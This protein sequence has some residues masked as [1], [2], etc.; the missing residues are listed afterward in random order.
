[1]EENSTKTTAAKA[2]Q[3][4]EFH[5]ASELSGHVKNL[6][7]AFKTSRVPWEI[8]WEELWYNYLGQYNATLNWRSKTEGTGGRSKLFI[9]LTTLKCNTAHAKIIDILFAGHGNVPFD[10]IVDENGLSM[11]IDQAKNEVHIVKERLAEHFRSIEME[12]TMDTGILELAIL[13]TGV[14]KAPI[15]ET[16]KRTIAV[17]RMIAGMPAANL[18]KDISPFEL[19]TFVENVAAMDHVPL[20]EYYTD[21]NAL[22]NRAAIGEIHFQRLLPARFRQLASNPSYNKEAIMEAARRATLTDQ[23]ST[24]YVQLADNYTGE[25]GDKDK[26]VS[27]LEYWGLVPVKYLKDVG[28]ELPDGI[29]DED[30]EIEALVVLAADGIVCKACVN[31]LGFRPF[32]VCP[33]KKRPHVIYGMGVAEM[34]R[35]SQKMGNSAIR[36]MI[37]NKA[38]SGNGMISINIDRIDQ[39][40]S[41]GLNVFPGKTFFTKGQYAPKDAIDSISFPDVTAGLLDLVTLCERFS[42]EET[43]IP[44]YSSGEQDNFMNKTAHGMAMLMTQ[45]NI[46]LKSTLKNIDNF[47]IEPIVEAF[48]AWFTELS[49]DPMKRLPI[50]VKAIGADSLIAKELKIESLLKLLQVT[51]APSDAILTNRPKIIKEI[52]RLLDNDDFMK[53]DKEIAEILQEMAKMAGT[54]KDLR[55][56]VDID[57]MYPELERSEQIQILQQMSIQPDMNVPQTKAERD[58]LVKIEIEK[59]KAASKAEAKAQQKQGGANANK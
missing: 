35:D 47:W 2:T 36:L 29:E 52:A 20:W 57:R 25:Q 48:Y 15:I 34:M 32:F 38:Y 40:R 3:A 4:N 6:F 59:I 1:M 21:I 19:K 30:E 55:E 28:A 44:K 51:A 9:K 17:E 54:Q 7:E 11:P 10:L 24:R 39:K 12:E 56:M 53:G 27:V 26:R 45:A 37:D 14:L 18:S 46:N 50:K 58:A 43:G 13:G 42:D 31:P 5:T 23:S 8:L 33:Y 41:K 22:S 49:P 16:R